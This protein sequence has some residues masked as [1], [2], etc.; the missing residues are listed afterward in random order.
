MSKT[1]ASLRSAAAVARLA[2]L[3]KQLARD[4]ASLPTLSIK[5]GSKKYSRR[6]YLAMCNIP[7]SIQKDELERR[8]RV[9]GGDH[10]G[11]SPTINLHGIEFRAAMLSGAQTA[12]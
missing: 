4:A 1:P 9:F 6:D 8:I 2:R 10:F 12:T 11:I 3:A 7:L 5:W